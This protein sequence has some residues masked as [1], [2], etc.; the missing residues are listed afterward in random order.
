MKRVFIHA[1]MAGNLGDDLMVRILCGRYPK[2]HFFVFA[3]GSYHIRYR[4]IKNL[5]VFAPEDRKTRI[6]N[7][8]IKKLTGKED[9]VRKLAAPSWLERGL[10]GLGSSVSCRC[11][12]VEASNRVAFDGANRRIWL[13]CGIVQHACASPIAMDSEVSRNNDGQL[14][15]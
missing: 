2:V 6:L 8:W 10:I 1:F 15:A 11:C 3:D 5:T 13:P 9:G 14:R 4:N 7:R 12:Q